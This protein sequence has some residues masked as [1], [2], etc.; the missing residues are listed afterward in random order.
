[1]SYTSLPL[2]PCTGACQ[3][4]VAQLTPYF[5]ASTSP[6]SHLSSLLECTRNH[7]YLLQRDE[8]HHKRNLTQNERKHDSGHSRDY[9]ENLFC[10]VMRSVT[11]YLNT[12]SLFSL[13]TTVRLHK[14]RV[15]QQLEHFFLNYFRWETYSFLVKLRS[16][17]HLE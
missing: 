11:L 14:T 12:V 4:Q 6:D 13:K 17:R 15:S 16:N 5:F 2:Q 1:M 8:F 7:V 9:L 3:G 10:L